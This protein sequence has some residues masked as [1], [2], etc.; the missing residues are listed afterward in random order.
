MKLNGQRIVILGG[1]SGIGLATARAVAEQGADV[2]VASSRR[3]SV[4]AALD[5]LPARAQG[6]VLDMSDSAA[7]EAFF[8]TLGAFDHLVY[9]AGEALSLMPL[10]DMDIANARA[11]FE[12]RYWG[13]L[14]AAKAARPHI[15]AGG[16]IVFTGGIA[17]ARPGP[18]WAVAA[19][20]CS[21]MEGLTRAL[22]VELAPLR[23]NVVAPGVVR[24]P[25]WREW[26]E[27]SREAFYAERAKAI[28]VG[29]VGEPEEI[30]KAYVYLMEQ[31]Y[32]SGQTLVV[33]GGNVLV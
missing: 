28:P 30:A 4:D 22:A 29:H 20:I 26:D 15:R 33:D 8:E 23:V 1:T 31:T 12:L 6:H 11:F 18:G 19:S 14:T 17:G 3:V 13:A 24:T 32:G 5:V 27:A 16:S 7:I 10:D 25:L 2:V 21:A 9:T